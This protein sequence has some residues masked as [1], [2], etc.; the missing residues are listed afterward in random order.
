MRLETATDSPAFA[1]HAKNNKDYFSMRGS[2]NSAQ[3]ERRIKRSWCHVPH[4]EDTETMYAFERHGPFYGKG[5]F[6][7]N[8]V[9][10]IRDIAGLAKK[11]SDLKDVYVTSGLIAPVKDEEFVSP[12]PLHVHHRTFIPI[13]YQGKM[14]ACPTQIMNGHFLLVLKLSVLLLRERK[15]MLKA[16]RQHH[17]L[18]DMHHVLF[19]SR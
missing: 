1:K 4:P 14:K 18:E 6:D 15:I 3:W 16:K 5:N 13:S 9:D 2:D 19:Q 7:W 8:A 12:P 11:W 10:G 17:N